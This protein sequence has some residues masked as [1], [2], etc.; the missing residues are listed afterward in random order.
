MVTELPTVTVA[1]MAGRE[2]MVTEL[3]TVTVPEMAGREPMVTEF[4]IVTDD[5]TRVAFQAGPPCPVSSATQE[6]L[7]ETT[8]PS[9]N[10]TPLISTSS[11]VML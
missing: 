6:L 11:G 2:P 7:C 10:A 3:P 5:A 1:E 4:E 9:T 8:L